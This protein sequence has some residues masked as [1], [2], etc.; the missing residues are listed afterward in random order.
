MGYRIDY[1]PDHMHR[2]HKIQRGH[3][4][5]LT[6]LFLLLFGMITYRFWPEGRL[7]LQQILIPGDPAVTLPAVDS[8][9]FSLSQGAN[10]AAALETFCLTILEGSG[11]AAF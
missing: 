6:W 9:L 7:I 3:V 4:W 5:T 2:G 11:F 8:L 10:A 1:Q